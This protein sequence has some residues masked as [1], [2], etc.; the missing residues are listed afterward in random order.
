M[1]NKD[2]KINIKTKNKKLFK[3][4]IIDTL[5][6]GFGVVIPT[7]GMIGIIY[8]VYDFI[9]NLLS[10]VTNFLNKYMSFPELLTDII[11]LAI[12][13]FLC[14]MCGVLLK[15][16]FGKFMYFFY[17]KFLK[18]IR[19]FK[20]FNILKEIYQQLTNDKSNAFREFVMAKP[21][22]NNNT[23]VPA[24]IVEEYKNSK[25]ETIYIVFAP[26]VPNPT[27]GFSYHLTINE[28]DRYPKL[29]VEQAFRSILSCGAG[30]G[31]LIEKYK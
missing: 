20:I 18:K 31:E 6:G 24:F 30:M 21:F 15:T 23:S 27:S 1:K 29:P 11:T 22:G 3:N 14:F 10:P 12:V 7:V 19:V 2:K 28:I 9:L 4:I 13:L 17:E 16:S 26:T 25:G 5:K 8:F